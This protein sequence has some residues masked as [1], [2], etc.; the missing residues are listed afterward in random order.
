MT[1][2]YWTIERVEKALAR[3]AETDQPCADLKADVERSKHKAKAIHSAIFLRM[4]GTVRER[5][6]HADSSELY[7]DAM[8]EYFTAIEMYEGMRNERSKEE[9]VIET[10]RSVNSA[11]NKGQFI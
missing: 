3:L 7:K 10:W 1:D 6:A 5:E 9:L 2:K 8:D 11:R 4:E